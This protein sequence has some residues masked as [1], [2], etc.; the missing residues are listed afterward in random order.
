MRP[1]SADKDREAIAIELVST[2]MREKDDQLVASIFEHF[3]LLS[4]P[5]LFG[6]LKFDAWDTNKSKRF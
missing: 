5:V 6:L 4:L 2:C 1:N 3:P